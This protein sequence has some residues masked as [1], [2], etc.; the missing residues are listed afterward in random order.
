MRRFT[1]TL[2]WDD[3]WFRQLP[4]CHKLVFLYVVDRCNNAGF[5]EVDEDAI[6]WHT[7]IES[8]H[9]EGAWKGLD[10]GIKGASGWVWVRTFLK[11][12][13]NEPLN[14]SN[15]AHK[16]I[17]ALIAAQH[18]RFK[19]CAEFRVFIAPY[20]GL[21][22]PIG[23]GKGTGKGKR[24]SPEREKI[25]GEIYACYPRKVARP[26]AIK[27]ICGALSR[28]Y[29][30]VVLMERTK[31]YAEVRAAQKNG[32]TPHP[33][34]WFNQERFNDDPETWKDQGN[35]ERPMTTYDVEKRTK[36]ISAEINK[37]FKR[38]GG[39]RVENDG[40]DELKKR[41]DELQK[42]LTI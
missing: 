38:N 10:R 29:S 17:I 9:L 7:K 36:A 27:A 6:C 21:F 37:I 26:D 19:D 33:A 30:P 41:R 22:S 11:H 12:Q 18:E 39:K 40:I 3:P 14:P 32:F 24:E 4:G 16:Q 13:K 31:A 1:D 20:K 34:T 35:G 25:A 23:I 15:P 8:K 42:Q 2:K 5:W 28:G